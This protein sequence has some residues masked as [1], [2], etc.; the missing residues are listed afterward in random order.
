M[1]RLDVDS[2]FILLVEARISGLM[3]FLR[4]GELL[5][6]MSLLLVPFSFSSWGLSCRR[7]GFDPI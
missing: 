6:M 2:V 4:F 5:A 1:G 3:S 7:V